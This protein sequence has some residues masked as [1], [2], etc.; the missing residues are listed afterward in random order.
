MSKAF[1]RDHIKGLF[2]GRANAV[3]RRPAA[4]AAA[5]AR[6]LGLTLG[7]DSVRGSFNGRID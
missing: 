2:K 5:A 3:E 7:H 4:A 1:R 6:E